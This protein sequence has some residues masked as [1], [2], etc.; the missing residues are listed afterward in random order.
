MGVELIG[1]GLDMKNAGW[2]YLIKK[3]QQFGVDVSELVKQ[4][5]KVFVDREMAQKMADAL[6]QNFA[7]LVEEYFYACQSPFDLLIM[8]VIP[9]PDNL[10]KPVTEGKAFWQGYIDAFRK[11]NGFDIWT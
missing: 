4:E 8:K 7:E 3:L 11:C 5:S 2:Y 6:E 10:Y 9:S 1:T